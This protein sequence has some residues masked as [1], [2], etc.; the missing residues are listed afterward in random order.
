[1]GVSFSSRGEGA[2][3][4]PLRIPLIGPLGAMAGE[5]AALAIRQLGFFQLRHAAMSA[6]IQRER[7]GKPQGKPDAADPLA[8]SYDREWRTGVV[9]TDLQDHWNATARQTGEDSLGFGIELDGS[10]RC[11]FLQRVPDN[12]SRLVV[13]NPQGVR[14]VRRTVVK[15]RTR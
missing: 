1:M 6:S 8:H 11:N 7:R 15:P 3:Q 12:C 4:R 14:E 10:V 5:C 13:D 2:F 9:P